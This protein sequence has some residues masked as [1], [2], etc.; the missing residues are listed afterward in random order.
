MGET[1]DTEEMPENGLTWHPV[2]PFSYEAARL[3]CAAHFTQCAQDLE[4]SFKKFSFLSHLI[5][6]FGVLLN[7]FV[8]AS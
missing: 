4:I 5:F 2:G 3:A 7:G 1:P 8:R 6:F